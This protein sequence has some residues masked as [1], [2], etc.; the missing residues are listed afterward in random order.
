MTEKQI[1]GT[2]RRLTRLTQKQEGER[3]QKE[4]G[5]A[6]SRAKAK[7]I[8]EGV[9]ASD[10]AKLIT[11]FVVAMIILQATE[12]VFKKRCY[13]SACDIRRIRDKP[14][15][16]E[17]V[18][19]KLRNLGFGAEIVC[20]E[21][22]GVWKSDICKSIYAKRRCWPELHISWGADSKGWRRKRKRPY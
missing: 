11:K 18:L 19:Q 7:I 6:K 13:T 2:L 16:M 4:Q 5:L 21:G 10:N 14:K 9:Y 22:H 17:R 8:E 3:K 20:G 1:L 12:D 15:V